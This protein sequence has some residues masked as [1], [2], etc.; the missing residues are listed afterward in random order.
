MNSGQSSNS[1]HSSRPRSASR[2]LAEFALLSAITLTGCA[3]NS[4]AY[5]DYIMQ[6]QVL[7]VDGSSLSVCV[8][9]REGAAVGQV[10]QVVR[11]VRRPTP[12]KATNPS[13]AREDV[14]KVRIASL[15]DEHYA[16][17]VVI[18]GSPQVNDEVVL[19]HR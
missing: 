2:M 15:F 4:P 10:L 18:E 8:G 11:H 17:A 9:E 1:A 19:E 7:S 14:G 6:G 13:F 5:H 12:P 3:T 16:N